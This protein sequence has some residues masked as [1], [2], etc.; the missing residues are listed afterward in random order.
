MNFII[1]TI[2]PTT[3]CVG[4]ALKSKVSQ[5]MTGLIATLSLILALLL[6]LLLFNNII[7]NGNAEYMY[8]ANWITSNLIDL[9][10]NLNFDGTTITML[11]LITSISGLVHL[12][13]IEYM[14]GE[15]HKSRFIMYLSV[16]T[17]AMLIL[18]TAGNFVQLF[19]GWEGVGICSFLLINFWFTRVQAVKSAVLAVVMN[20]V[21][22]LG[23]TMGLLVTFITFASFQF[24]VILGLASLMRSYLIVM[25]KTTLPTVFWISLF[26]FIGAVG[27]SAQFPL[28]GWLPSAMEGPT[29]V[30]ALLH[31]S[32]M[33]TAGVF[34]M[35]RLS[36]VLVLSKI[37]LTI[38][39]CIGAITALLA[40]TIAITQNDIKKVIAFS[41]TSQLGY[42]IF[43][44]GLC[45]FEV[46][47]AHLF[48]HGFFKSL[49]FLSAGAIIHSIL[50]EDQDMRKM[51]SLIKI[52]PTVY[53]SMFAA[54]LAIIGYP[55]LSGFFSKDMILELAF[56]SYIFN[57]AFAF[58]FGVSAAFITAAYSFRLLAFVFFNSPQ[59]SK[60]T[61]IKAHEPKFYMLFPIVLLAFP[62]IFSGFS[63]K[64]LF[65][66]LGSPFWDNSLI[67][68]SSFSFDFEFLSPFIKLFPVFI[69]LTGALIGTFGYLFFSTS[70]FFFTTSF[71]FVFLSNKWFVDFLINQTVVRPSLLL[72]NDIY[73]ILDTGFFELFG[74]TGILNFGQLYSRFLSKLQ[75]GYIFHYS[76]FIFL[77][78]TASFGF[79]LLAI[80]PQF[81]FGEFK[82]WFAL[83]FSLLVI[84]LPSR[85]AA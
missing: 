65:L 51:G 41:T 85:K 56:A 78:V 72:G 50:S 20:R 57:G 74:P 84:S 9:K 48:G 13:S 4:L 26:C 62:S 23:L 61:Y 27:K 81:S 45:K 24:P 75:S 79:I 70:I 15:A 32:T 43:I 3:V 71:I 82:L 68:Q 80:N 58:I 39:T 36:P 83:I 42:M 25:F 31:S 47:L 66:G 14:D 28:N 73:K 67:S 21:G 69:S 1:L 8:L 22:D 55:F 77:S 40:G 17:F 46:S 10:Y 5:N 37:V 11:V 2:I 54:T 34:L 7:T 60:L 19:I 44:A 18:V 12:Y 6:S 52:L 63:T 16:F 53:A 30:S 49:L 76:Y 33:V 38:M 64:E 35:I 59:N 29:P